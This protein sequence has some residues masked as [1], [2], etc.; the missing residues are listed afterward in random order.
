MIAVAALIGDAFLNPCGQPLVAAALS[1]GER[2][3]RRLKLS[4]VF[5][6]FPV[7]QR[8]ERRRNR[9]QYQSCRRPRE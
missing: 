1:A 4:R 6:L 3:R 7:A 5:D 8:E 9:D 2:R